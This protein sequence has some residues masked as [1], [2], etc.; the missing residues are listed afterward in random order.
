MN[1]KSVIAA[2]AAA[3]LVAAQ[4]PPK[5]EGVKTVKSKFHEGISISYKKTHVC[6]TTPGVKSYAGE[7]HFCLK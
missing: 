6:E 2:I 5:P 1:F 7:Y 3:G 4:F